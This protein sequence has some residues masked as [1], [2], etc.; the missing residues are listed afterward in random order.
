MT[1][2]I[3]HSNPRPIPNQPRE[4]ARRIVVGAAAIAGLVGILAGRP[5]LAVLLRAGAVC[6]GGIFVIVCT[7]AIL[8][9]ARRRVVR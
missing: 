4:L 6:G 7:E 1:Q 2:P 3:L 5:L 9:R 8:R